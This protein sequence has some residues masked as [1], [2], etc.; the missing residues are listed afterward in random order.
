MN[1][2]EFSPAIH[3]LTQNGGLTNLIDQPPLYERYTYIFQGYSQVLDH[4]LVSPN[5]A[6]RMNV[7]IAHVNSDLSEGLRSSDHD[8]VLAWFK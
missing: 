8:P 4:I 7:R 1:D 6:P 2:F 5:L 3:I